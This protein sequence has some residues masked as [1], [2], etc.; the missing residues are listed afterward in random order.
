VLLDSLLWGLS[1]KHFINRLTGEPLMSTN[2]D[3]TALID[4][5]LP[6]N[7]TGEISASD[8]RTVAYALNTAKLN[9]NETVSSIEYQVDLSPPVPLQSGSVNWSSTGYNA[10]DFDEFIITVEVIIDGVTEIVE[11]TVSKHAFDSVASTGSIVLAHLTKA[12]VG[13]E[14]S[15]MSLR[16]SSETG[17]TLVVDE[18]SF[19]GK[20]VRIIGNKT[21]LLTDPVN[22]ELFDGQ[23]TSETYAELN[24]SWTKYDAVTIEGKVT[25]GVTVGNVDVP[26]IIRFSKTIYLH[27]ISE[28]TGNQVVNIDTVYA[29]ETSDDKVIIRALFNRT[30]ASKIYIFIDM[31]GIFGG[32]YVDRITGVNT[33]VNGALKAVRLDTDNTFNG[34]IVISNNNQGS[35]NLVVED[36]PNLRIEAGRPDEENLVLGGYPV[37]GFEFN[38]SE[39]DVED[40]STK[41]FELRYYLDEAEVRQSTQSFM[42]CHVNGG[43]DIT[44]AGNKVLNTF[45]NGIDISSQQPTIRLLNTAGGALG[46]SYLVSDLQGDTV[47]CQSNNN[48]SFEAI[49]AKFERGGRT[50]LYDNGEARLQTRPDGFECV[51]PTGLG[52]GLVNTQFYTS[53]AIVNQLEMYAVDQGLTLKAQSSGVVEIFYKNGS[54][55]TSRIGMN[56]TH[57]SLLGTWYGTL[58]SDITL[59]TNIVEH[60]DSLEKLNQLE[61]ISWDWKEGCEPDQ[62]GGSAN[63]GFSA[64][65]LQKVFPHLVSEIPEGEKNEG[66]LRVTK[67]I[68]DLSIESHLV[69]AI[70]QLTARIEELEAKLKD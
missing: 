6:D 7:N 24:D 21:R 19:D 23:A 45:V 42:K 70:Q 36:V 29:D 30:D 9:N 31:K 37:R 58:T 39:A 64:Q 50:T 46:S 68:S 16:E 65:S 43:V 56:T 62:D 1:I 8:V 17:F 44:H 4:S 59:K 40:D 57:S 67:P 32:V 2:T 25:S 55:Y 3:I 15:F 26:E 49:F 18:N 48:G 33:G 41:V 53:A 11:T 12:N 52:S 47:L 51:G 69:A 14:Y 28:N 35:G 22:V 38:Y 66:K 5:V 63:I 54:A 61:A 60:S 20:L 34:D 27:E 10:S 13:N